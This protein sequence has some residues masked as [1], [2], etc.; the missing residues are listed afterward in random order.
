M[1]ALLLEYALTKK[2]GESLEKGCFVLKKYSQRAQRRE[3]TRHIFKPV[4]QGLC[5]ASWQR[6]INTR[7]RKIT[8]EM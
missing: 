5:K 6:K 7:D 3:V 4:T 1:R 2:I 8:S